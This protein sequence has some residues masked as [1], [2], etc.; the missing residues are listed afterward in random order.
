MTTIQS[1]VANPT[2]SVRFLKHYRSMDAVSKCS[3]DE[4]FLNENVFVWTQP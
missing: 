1:E 4:V 2:V 3:K